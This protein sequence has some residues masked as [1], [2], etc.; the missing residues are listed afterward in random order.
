[1]TRRTPLLASLTALALGFGPSPAAAAAA[2]KETA[3]VLQS[4]ASAYSI[5]LLV[6]ATPAWLALSPE[7]RFGF[8]EEEIQGR[9]EDHPAVS[10]RFWD[11]E[12]FSARV[13]D[14]LL[15]ET[16]DL[17]QYRSLVEGIRETLFWDHYFEVLEILPGI[18]NAYA[19][20]Y[21]VAPFGADRD[22]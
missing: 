8:L 20:H 10:L 5:F 17:S 3:P 16:Q 7:E 14:V 6:R 9:L 11:V 2:D 15:F 19:E 13:S 1:M 21:E 18:E 4:E 12:H 22:R